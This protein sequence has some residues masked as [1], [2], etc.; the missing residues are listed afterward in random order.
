[1]IISY[2]K[3]FIFV[4]IYKTAGTSIFSIF[5]RYAKFSTLVSEVWPTRF[6]VKLINIIFSLENYGNSWING[7]QKHASCI[8]INKYVGQKFFTKFYKFSFVRNP[9]DL[10]Y[11]L[12]CYEK[13]SRGHRNHKE[14]KNTS[15]D[16]F[17]YNQIKRGAP[18]QVHF[19]KIDGKIA[20][21]YIG[22]FEHLNNSIKTI[23]DRL[24]IP[25]VA[26]PKFN[27]SNRKH[28]SLDNIYTSE[29]ADIVYEYFKD[30]FDVLGYSKDFKNLNPI[31]VN[32]IQI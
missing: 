30:D 31:N 10:Q 6:F 15:F 5:S 7:V 16:E 24:N 32:N 14:A 21:D 20:V 29:L 4:H 1:M 26:I 18:C 8:E 9:Y 17:I 3:K 2:K 11:S 23:C 22:Y 28:K 13:K 27:S 12:W 19:L 25:L